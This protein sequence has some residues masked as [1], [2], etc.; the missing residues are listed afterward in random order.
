M[1]LAAAA[2]QC[3]RPTVKP[4]QM[5]PKRELPAWSAVTATSIRL[6]FA[7]VAGHRS[8]AAP[9]RAHPHEKWRQGAYRKGATYLYPGQL[10]P[11]LDYE[12][13]LLNG[14]NIQNIQLITQNLL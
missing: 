12:F 5:V 1:A 2:Y 14:E 4:C 8:R 11:V 7:V 13:W 3:P 9:W 10:T 6:T